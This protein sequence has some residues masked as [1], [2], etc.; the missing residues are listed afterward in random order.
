MKAF[1][2]LNRSLLLI[3]VV[4]CVIMAGSISTSAQTKS[5]VQ[6]TVYTGETHTGKC[7]SNWEA[8]VSINESER[9]VPIVVTWSTDYRSNAPFF[10]ALRLNGGPCV[11]YGPAYL[12]ASAPGDDTFASKTFQWV[13]MPGDYKLSRGTNV[14]QVC[15]GGIFD[16]T[17]SIT[18]GFNTLTAHLQK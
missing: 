6:R 3:A 8:S 13:I 10:A 11:F 14:I 7:C 15:G 18:L 17:D 16:D 1:W 4:S 5:A 12:P 9:V 2:E